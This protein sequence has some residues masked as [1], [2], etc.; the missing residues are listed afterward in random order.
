MATTPF[1]TIVSD[2][3]PIR[4]FVDRVLPRWVTPNGITCVRVALVPVVVAL[5]FLHRYGTAC[6]IFIAAMLLDLL[7][8][9]LA[10]VRGQVTEFGKL[11]D[12]IADKVTVLIPLWVWWIITKNREAVTD[13]TL[14]AIVVITIVELLL[15]ELRLRP[16]Y[17]RTT[18]QEVRATNSAGKVKVWFEGWMVGFLLFEPHEALLQ[19]LALGCAAVAITLALW[20]LRVHYAHARA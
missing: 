11:L 16:L 12:P 7:D 1:D 17:T 9:P 20:S 14:A 10:R 6:A 4:R 19:F 13:V 15:L 2:D 3:R 18:V 8:G 5:V